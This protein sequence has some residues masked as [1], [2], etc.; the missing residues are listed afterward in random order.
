MPEFVKYWPYEETIYIEGFGK[1]TYHNVKNS[2]EQVINYRDKYQ[3]INVLSNH[4]H[5]ESVPDE[6]DVFNLGSMIGQILKNCFIAIIYPQQFTEYYRLFE[7][8]ANTRGGNIK[9]FTN[10]HSAFI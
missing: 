3:I 5:V 7:K 4:L 6:V 2:L 10:T 8:A 1:I 9:L